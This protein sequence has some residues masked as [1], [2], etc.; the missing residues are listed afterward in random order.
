MRERTETFEKAWGYAPEGDQPQAIAKLVM[1]VDTGLSEQVLLGVTGSGKTFT[2]ANVIAET[3]RPALIMAHNKTL[4]A[5]LFQEMKELFPNNAVEYFI[6]Y[7]DYYQPEAYVPSTDTFIDKVSAINSDIDKMRHSATRTLLE[8]RDVI[9][10][11]SVSCIYG[12]GSPEAYLKAMVMVEKGDA[13]SRDEL[14]RRLLEIQYQRNDVSLERGKF[15]V[16]GDVVEIVPSHEKDRAIRIQFWGRKVERI[17]VIDALRGQVIEETKRVAIYPSSHHVADK[18][19]L[20]DILL[21]IHRDLTIQLDLFRREGKFVEAQRLEQ[22]VLHDIDM[23]REVGYCQGIEN[24]SR[25]MDGR[26]PGAPPAT[27][28]DYFPR[29]FLLFL[30]ES[31]VTLP[32][33]GGMYRGDRARKETLVN[34]GFRLP[35]ALDNRPLNF[36]EFQARIGQTIYVSATPGPYEMSRSHGEIVEQIIRPTGLIDP[37]IDVRPATHQIDDLLDEIRATIA[38]KARILV[39]TLTKK[40][41]EEI[42]TYFADLGIKVKY[43][44]SD[45]DSIERVEILRDLRIGVFDVLVGINLLREGL[46]LPEV[47]L[48]AILDADKEGFLRSRTSLIQTVGRAA[49][50]VNGRVIMYA[51]RI[52]DSIRQ[53]LDETDRRRRIQQDYNTANGITPR[54]INKKIPEQLLK[55]Y[56]LDFGE[57]HD[58]KMLNLLEAIGDQNL[59]KSPVKV[60]KE[61]ARMQKEM[62]K[63]SQKLDFEQA[64]SLRDKVNLLKSHLQNLYETR[65]ATEAQL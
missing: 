46:D 36:E 20:D 37:L 17:A 4:A 30:D 54:G 60:E 38:R 15:R 6:S 51:D 49:R 19:R 1:G 23:F 31:H 34:Y 11:S 57:E 50:N 59:L 35:S 3:N 7:Y 27:L 18:E 12:L 44:H 61:I 52:T 28:I 8:R 47:E 29:D 64:A 40:M 21:E 2:M 65:N 16:R 24:Y 62:Q 14:L 32:Q 53:T 25:Y 55:L 10:V 39:T 13:L 41:A 56:N 58:E 9:I 43:L 45:I 5:Q 42:T 26:P 48:V 22:R 33:V 63:A